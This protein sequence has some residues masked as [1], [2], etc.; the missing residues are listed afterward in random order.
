ML[1]IKN[2]NGITFMGL[3]DILNRVM[4]SQNK[5]SFWALVE[6]FIVLQECA[7]D[8]AQLKYLDTLL[9]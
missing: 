8:I 6:P 9:A 3:F 5:D 1:V 2:E 7:E 4:S